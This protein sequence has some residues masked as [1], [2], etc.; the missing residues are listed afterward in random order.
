MLFSDIDTY[1]RKEY[2]FWGYL[3]QRC[4]DVCFFSVPPLILYSLREGAMFQR[5][6]SLCI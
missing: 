2:Y 3:L 4:L 6:W 5:L 1:L